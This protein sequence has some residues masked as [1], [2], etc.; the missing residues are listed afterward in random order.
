[1]AKW[2]LTVENTPSQTMESIVHIFT[3]T[4]ADS[5]IQGLWS[6]PCTP[7]NALAPGFLLDPPIAE[8][9][10]CT[11]IQRSAEAGKVYTLQSQPV[12]MLRSGL[13]ATGGLNQKSHFLEARRRA[14]GSVLRSLPSCIVSTE[15]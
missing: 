7:E 4:S 13:N 12:T 5:L 6:A 2:V 10:P 3:L 9:N 1:M 15:H 8:A 11:Q 14:A